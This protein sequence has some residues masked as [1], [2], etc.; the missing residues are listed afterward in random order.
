MAPGGDAT[1]VVTVPRPALSGDVTVTV[2]SLP[3]GV[4]VEP[5]TIPAAE[6]HGTLTAHASAEAAVDDWTLTVTVTTGNGTLTQ[7]LSLRVASDGAGAG[8]QD[9]TFGSGGT[10][11]AGVTIAGGD[12]YLGR[13]NAMEWDGTFVG[14]ARATFDSVQSSPFVLARFDVDGHLI[15]SFGDGGVVTGPDSAQLAPV[16]QSGYPPEPVVS[17]DGSGGAWVAG[18]FSS[19]DGLLHYDPTGALTSQTTLSLDPRWPAV[20]WSGAT[21]RVLVAGLSGG[22]VQV[23]R[24]NEGAGLDATFANKGY[25]DTGLGSG[26]VR[27]AVAPDG[28]FYVVSEAVSA[29]VSVGSRVDD[30]VTT[31]VAHFSADGVADTAFGSGGTAVVYSGQTTSSARPPSLVVLPDALLVGTNGTWETGPLIAKLTLTGLPYQTWGHDGVVRPAS[32]PGDF[33][34]D[35]ATDSQGRMLI[36]VLNSQGAVTHGPIRRL[37]ANG[38]DD[39]GFAPASIEGFELLVQPDDKIVVPQKAGLDRLFYVRLLP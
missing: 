39:P 28:S 36:T 7:P 18:E 24:F 11:R 3:T 1:V 37:L 22:T 8:Q 27:L 15:S 23:A 4:T 38:I 20:Q 16:Y 10:A 6:D 26:Q 21:P 35:L 5:L 13:A 14:V 30:M 12:S 2:S 31:S 34:D 29:G 33:L 32:A 25:L 19:G 9:L 17:N